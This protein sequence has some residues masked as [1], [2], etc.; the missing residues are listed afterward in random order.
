MKI[1]RYLTAGASVLAMAAMTCLATSASAR[2]VYRPYAAGNTPIDPNTPVAHVGPHQGP[3]VAPSNAKSG[4]WT[5]V[6]GTLPFT[7]GPWGAMLLTDGTVIIE[8]YCTAPNQWYKLTPDKTGSYVNGTWSKIATMP[9]G[10]SPLFFAQQVLPDGRVIINGGE[11]NAGSNGN[12]GGGVWTNKG[13]LYD[14]VKNSWTTVAAPSGWSQIGDA[15]SIVLPD[16][17]YMLANCCDNPG[18]N[19]LASINGTKVTWT[20]QKSFGYNDEEGFNPLPGGDVLSVDV[21][22]HTTTSDDTWIYDT[23]AGTWSQGANTSCYLSDTSTFELGPAVVRP[24]GTIIQFGDNASC[25]S[26]YTISTG[27]WTSAPNFGSGYDM[28]DA[29][30]ALLPDGN[31]LAQASPGVFNTPS[32]F[33]EYSIDSKGKQSLTQ[34]NDP[35]QA[36]NSSSYF[37]NLVDLPSGQVLWDDSQAQVSEVALYTPKGKANKSWKPKIK[38]VSASLSIGST[39]NAISGKNFNG[40]SLGGS[41]GDDAQA[42]SNFPIVRITNTGTGDVCYARSYNFSTMGVWT[43]GTTKADFDIPA[44]CESGAST[45]QVI[46]NGI[47]SGAKSVTL[48]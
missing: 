15:E 31:V 37:G 40:F 13:A 29:P 8:D 48:S 16:G 19:A 2:P 18:Y 39:G 26:L 20:T 47:A 1:N 35:K 23:S 7:D 44:T 9:S 33:F 5:D 21:W 17:T 12:C 32:H 34:V 36:A 6:K 14:P 22:N 46:V 4:T 3:Y 11:Y 28:A 10:Y 25:N 24:D 43:K 38:S 30:A 27:T 45:L 41:Y 42:A